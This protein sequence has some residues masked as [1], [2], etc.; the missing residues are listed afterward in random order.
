MGCWLRCLQAWTLCILATNQPADTA[1]SNMGRFCFEV[2]P[3]GS[4][5][6]SAGPASRPVSCSEPGSSLVGQT[7]QLASFEPQEVASVERKKKNV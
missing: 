3:G 1:A 7:H 6:L 5:V 4:D 2:G